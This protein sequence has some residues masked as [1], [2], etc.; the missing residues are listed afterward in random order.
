MTDP[1]FETLLRSPL[2]DE[3]EPSGWGSAVLGFVGGGVVVIALSLIL[4][5]WTT[6]DETPSTNPAADATTTET[7]A[8]VET[9][10]SYPDGFSDIGGSVAM[11][12]VAVVTGDD[13]FVVSFATTTDRASDPAATPGPLG[14]RWQ[15]ESVGGSVTGAT[16]LVYDRTHTGV[17]G[18]VFPGYPSEGDVIRMT[19][20]W[21]PDERTSS[22]EIPF[23]GTPFSTIDAAELDLGDGIT[24]RLDQLELGRHLGQVVWGL[25][26]EDNPKGVAAFEVEIVDDEG[27]AI[28][29]YLSMPSPRKPMP[30]GV[31]DLFWDQGFNA[32]PDRGSAVRIT[33]TVQLVSPE[34]VDVIYE[35]DSIPSGD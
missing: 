4:G 1:D 21:D 30:A 14:G 24:L 10:N 5:L 18:T 13:G 3:P 25:S 17:I 15:I 11:K 31:I 9:A 26:G 12:P 6:P 35:L 34:P 32:H 19:E 28:G 8:M 29:A 27:A 7:A 22:I 23:T 2:D 33:A 20:R 16:Q